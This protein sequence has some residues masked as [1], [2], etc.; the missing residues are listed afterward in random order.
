MTEPFTAACIQNQAVAD[1]DAS[2]EQATALVRAARGTGADTPAGSPT[3]R[4]VS[5]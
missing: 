5:E 2:I 4:I 3:L 1:M